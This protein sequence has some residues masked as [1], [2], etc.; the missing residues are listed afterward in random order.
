[1]VESRNKTLIANKYVYLPWHSAYL[2]MV[3]SNQDLNC[4]DDLMENH[5]RLVAFG[6]FSYF[7]K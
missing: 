7:S 3:N 1:M 4:F 6:Q 5:L 2:S